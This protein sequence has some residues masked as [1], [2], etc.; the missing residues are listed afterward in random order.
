MGFEKIIIK[1]GMQIMFFVNSPL[2]D[3]YQSDI[4]GNI[5]SN[6]NANPNTFSLL[7]KD[8]KLRTISRNV[9]SIEMAYANLSILAKNR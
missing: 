9:T 2:T 5:L 3:Y 8:G 6:V 7:Q 4:F 1:N